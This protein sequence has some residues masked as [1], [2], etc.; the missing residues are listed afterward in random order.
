MPRLPVILVLLCLPTLLFAQEVLPRRWSHIPVNMNFAGGGAAY[1]EGDI[2]FDPV[3]NVT[4]AEFELTTYA[5][6][7]IRS[8]EL[9]GKS[10]RI[11]LKAAYQTGIW[12][13]LRDGEPV[14]APRSGLADPTVRFAVNLLGAPP[15]EG[16]DFQ[17]YRQA[18]EQE[19]LV[20]AALVLGLP[21]GEYFEDRLINLGSNRFLI[22]PQLGLVHSRG[23]WTAELTGAVWFF[24]DNN[25]FWNGNKLEQAPLLAG[26]GHLIYTFRPGLWAGASGAYGYGAEATV[27]GVKKN[28][29]QRNQLFALSIGVPLNRQT[30]FKLSWV[31]AETN[32][33]M[34]VDSNTIALSGSYFW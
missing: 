23:K 14:E 7:Y 11:D 31:K 1:T 28:N 30:G 12:E 2:S 17:T 25:E 8:F 18:H 5:G 6:S 22:R 21:L 19:T 4:E 13:G 16:A 15:L 27:N 32:V 3:L 29:E 26:Q 24:T 20:G 34:G 33:A 9:L 10:A